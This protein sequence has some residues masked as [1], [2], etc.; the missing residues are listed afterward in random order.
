[1]RVDTLETLIRR[2]LGE[3]RLIGY[4][5][6]ATPIEEVP[7]L[8]CFIVSFLSRKQRPLFIYLDVH[9]QNEKRLLEEITRQVVE[10][11]HGVIR[12]G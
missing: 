2:V 9:E 11:P 1:M 4:T 3:M 12:R 10:D 8:V 7:G 5:L 6:S